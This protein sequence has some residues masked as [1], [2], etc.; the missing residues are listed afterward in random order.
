ME[1][2]AL[3]T[4]AVDL[5]LAL[6]Q[7]LEAVLLEVLPEAVA[8]NSAVEFDRQ[9]FES[10]ERRASLPDQEQHFAVAAKLPSAFVESLNLPVVWV[11]FEGTAEPHSWGAF[12]VGH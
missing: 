10:W 1:F 4:V 5:G 12:A 9:V 2:V 3:H 7:V 6:A 11:Q 8:A